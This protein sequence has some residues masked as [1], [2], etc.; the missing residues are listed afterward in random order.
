M[1]VDLKEITRILELLGRLE[2]KATKAPWSM[3]GNYVIRGPQELPVGQAFPVVL[4]S[5]ANQEYRQ[6]EVD[7]ANTTLACEMRNAI[8]PLMDYLAQL[9][10]DKA[11]LL[12]AMAPFAGMNKTGWKGTVW[13]GK[14]SSDV[15]MVH[16]ATK[17]EI[18]LDHFQE[19]ERLYTEGIKQCGGSSSDPFG[20]SSDSASQQD[21]PL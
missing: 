12:Y 1:P 3:T 7:E 17:T 19:A 14:P 6:P 5:R 21:P 4:R 8:R 11:R 18:T 10:L 16:S 13:E 2:Q 9:E 20:S 15:V